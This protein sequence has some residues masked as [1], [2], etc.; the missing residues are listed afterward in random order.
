M[1]STKWYVLDVL[2]EPQAS[3]AVEY[4]LME[5]GALGTETNDAE[6]ELLRVTAYFDQVPN[7]ERVR[8]ELTEAFRIYQL[9]SS[10]AR[11]TT[12]REVVDQDWLGEWKKSW[13][14]V[15][16]GERFI[17]APPW[18]EIPSA[19]GRIVI[20]IEPGMAFGTGTHETTRLCLVAIENYF[21]GGS[22]LDV[23]T[24]T[25]ILAIAAAK[26]FPGAHI[27]ACDTD[28]E[29]ITIA[30]E[31]A[32]LNGVS[33]HTT[34]RI[35][36]LEDATPSADLVCANLTADVIVS[37]LPSLLS[38]TCGHLI[39][40]GILETQLEVIADALNN[41]GVSKTIE[42]AQDGEWLAIIV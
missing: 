26:L 33:E 1:S 12:V 41:T 2:I 28:A 17:I 39:L 23:G 15:E 13:Q 29:A 21:A 20:R 40:S 38:V 5:A 14:P 34:F 10:S 42:I 18:A 30:E 32:R 35:G 27:E 7:R 22:F 36:T 8:A 3:E 4:A 25:G 6:T 19:H 16:V 24:G 11:E 9:P 37:L 31:N